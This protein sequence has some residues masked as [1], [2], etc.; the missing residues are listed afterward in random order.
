LW[1][2]CEKSESF[3]ARGT[4]C[5]AAGHR[6]GFLMPL[7]LVAPSHARTVI[8]RAAAWLWA[9]L[10]RVSGRISDFGV[11]KSQELGC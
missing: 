11:G 6:A 3:E 4:R 9:R 5:A 7:M 8:G 1:N 2:A 10:L